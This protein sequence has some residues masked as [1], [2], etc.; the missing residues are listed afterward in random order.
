[1]SVKDTD[2]LSAGSIPI[3]GAGPLNVGG[4]IRYQT[5]F[6]EYLRSGIVDTNVNDFP[7]AKQHIVDA[8]YTNETFSVGGQC[9][10]PTGICFDG[11]YLWV[12]DGTNK[13]VFQY[14]LAGSYTNVSYDLSAQCNNPVCIDFDGTNFWVLDGNSN[15]VFK[16]AADFSY[17][18]F[19]FSVANEQT[20]PGGIGVDDLFVY[21]CGNSPDAV[22]QYDKQGI[23]TGLNYGVT[24]QEA[25]PRAIQ[26][27][28]GFVWVVGI[29]SQKAH[30]FNY[31]GEYTNINFDFSNEINNAQGA[32]LAGN[33][34]V[35]LGGF[36]VCFY[37]A[38]FV[39]GLVEESTDSDTGLPIYARIS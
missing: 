17:S 8:N 35:I 19:N 38:V 25:G 5:Q 34:F 23:A 7:N 12:V 4:V 26:A 3:N 24:N 28:D 14:T 22:A 37:E 21:V 9:G 31:R 33:K 30:Q 6:E 20:S 39:V 18:G 1:M 15:S 10:N 2:L 32:T 11:Q 36:D 27:H 29:G 16:F 13:T